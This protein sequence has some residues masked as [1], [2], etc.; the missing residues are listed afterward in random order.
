M[1]ATDIQKGDK[2]YFRVRV[3][4]FLRTLSGT[5]LEVDEKKYEASVEVHTQN[6]YG[7]KYNI[8]LSRLH[9]NKKQ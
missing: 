3:G 1:T 6:I 7:K 4:M 8:H 2:V 9:K 5:V